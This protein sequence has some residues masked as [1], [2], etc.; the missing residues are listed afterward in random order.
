[1]T[2]QMLP[3]SGAGVDSGCVSALLVASASPVAPERAVAWTRSLL[4]VVQPAQ[5]AVLSMMPVPRSPCPTRQQLLRKGIVS[6]VALHANKSLQIACQSDAVCCCLCCLC[7]HLFLCITY[8]HSVAAGRRRISG[9]GPMQQRTSFS[10]RSAPR[11]QAKSQSS[12][13]LRCQRCHLET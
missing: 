4:E 3:G 12:Q 5:L 8:T 7:G 9:V 6:T 1:M 10:I 11:R 13:T 2:L